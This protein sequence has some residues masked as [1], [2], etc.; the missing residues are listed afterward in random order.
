[1][2]INKAD[3]EKNKKDKFIKSDKRIALFGGVFD[4]PTLAHMILACEIYN[5]LEFIDEVWI[6]PF[7]DGRKD[8]TIRTSI[9][10]RINM[11]NRIKD[12]IIYSDLPIR[13]CEIEKENGCF[14]PTI[15]LLD[16][17]KSKYPSYFFYFAF[18]S[19]LIESFMKI[20]QFE[21]IVKEYRFILISRPGYE[22]D[23]T[24]S[25]IL[26]N[27]DIIESEL[28]ISSSTVIDRIDSLMKKKNKVH[29]ACSGMISKS[30]LDYIYEHELY[31]VESLCSDTIG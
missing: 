24:P 31:K 6:I 14:M 2:E 19:N 15:Q 23:K 27:S 5:N 9:N 18:G 28:L 7:G 17:L 20:D 8:K 12:D 11:L 22:I 30:V 4:P 10:H 29:L 3:N 1:M 16:S 25:Q 21:R 13:I 26:N